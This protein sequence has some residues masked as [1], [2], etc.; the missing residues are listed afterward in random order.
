MS[1]QYPFDLLPEPEF[2]FAN[3]YEG[4]SNRTA[5][6]AI[7]AFPDWPAPVFILSG[8]QGSGKTHLGQA[9]LAS[10]DNIQFVD[11]AAFQNDDDLFSV[12]NKALNGELDG[13][14]LASRE[15]PHKWRVGLP[16]LRSR[17]DYIPKITMTD[18]GD[19][20]LEPIIRKLFE[21]H[22]RSTKANIVQYIT[23]HYDRSVPAVSKLVKEIDMAARQQK[24]DVT[25]KFVSDFLKRAGA[26]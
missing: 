26:L 18:P 10:H 19:D 16:D 1:E 2:T 6:R 17:L 21:D 15:L 11:D 12:I 13:V 14:L 22:G 23:A 7:K 3:F 20:I 9:W 4:Q 24:R 25:R 8:P 5:L